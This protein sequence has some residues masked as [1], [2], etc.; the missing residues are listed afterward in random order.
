VEHV[1]HYV[2]SAIQQDNVST[3]QDV[4]AIRGRRWQPPFQFL[5]TW[6]QALLEP[7]WQS[8]TP[9][10]LLFQPWRQ[11]VSFRQA[12]RQIALMLAMPVAHDLAVVVLIEMIALVIVIFFMLVVALAVSM[13][14]TQRRIAR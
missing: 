14:L 11:L 9:G 8:A 1:D 10:K 2:G 13:P 5:G 6:L 12:W 4:R 3:D 7:W